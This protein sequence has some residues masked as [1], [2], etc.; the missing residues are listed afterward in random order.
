MHALA[1]GPQH[2]PGLCRDNVGRVIEIEGRIED[3]IV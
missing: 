2:A 3:A 1:I